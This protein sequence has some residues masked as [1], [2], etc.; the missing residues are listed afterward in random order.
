MKK[1]LYIIILLALPF[2]KVFAVDYNASAFGCVS[3]G[4]TNNTRSIQAA[5]DMISAKGGGTLNFYVGRYLTGGLELKS[6][7]TINLHEGAILVASPSFYDFIQKDGK[8]YF[9]YAEKQEN[10]KIIGKGVILGQAALVAPNIQNQVN[11]GF[12]KESVDSLLPTLVGFSHCQQITL[13]GIMLRDASGD[14]LDLNHCSQVTLKNQLIKA[15]ASPKGAG[16]RLAASTEVSLDS[17]Y[18][19]V[20]G[21]AL[22]K[23]ASSKISRINKSVTPN[24]KPIK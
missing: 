12:V 19:D 6:N 15:H 10:I 1:L 21:K 11:K 4:Q 2:G 24:G 22:V 23:D 3:D 20:A 13:D 14:V 7:V 8:R 9:I 5:I 16:L 17:M 18:V